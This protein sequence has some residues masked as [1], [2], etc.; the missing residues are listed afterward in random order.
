MLNKTLEK[1]CDVVIDTLYFDLGK[2]KFFIRTLQGKN[3]NI[4]FRKKR[5]NCQ[6]PRH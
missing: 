4:Y 2:R 1:F 3:G 6:Q 5:K